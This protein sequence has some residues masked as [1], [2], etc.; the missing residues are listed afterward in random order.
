M[1]RH[2]GFRIE[3]KVVPTKANI[4]ALRREEFRAQLSDTGAP[5]AAARW[6]DARAQ[7]EKLQNEISQIARKTGIS[8]ATKLALLA[9]DTP[10]SDRVP[11][12]EWWDSVILMTPEEREHKRQTSD[13][14]SEQSD[15][16][17]ARTHSQRVDACHVGDDNIV[18]NLNEAAITNL[19]EH[20]QQLRP[21]KLH[22]TVPKTPALHHFLSVF[23]GKK[24][25]WNK[26]P[27]NT[28]VFLI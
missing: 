23:A 28:W 11:D 21:P 26:L 24:K 27:S 8:S 7:L 20:P 16:S 3:T 18:D 1:V 2:I 15:T 5:D 22:E 25:W 17:D 9:A 12:I 10:D 6:H 13:A 14:T 19:V 4:R